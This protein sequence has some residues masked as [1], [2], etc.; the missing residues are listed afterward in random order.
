[1]A[2]TRLFNFSFF[3][4]EE[5]AEVSMAA[6][7]L[8]QGLWFLADR[9]GRLEDRPRRIKAD[10]FP[11][12][13]VDVESELHSLVQ[14]GF[15]QRY[16]VDGRRCIWVV[17]FVKHQHP[18]PHEAKSVLPPTPECN[19]MQL[20]VTE[21]NVIPG[22]VANTFTITSTV[23][24]AKTGSN[25]A[26]AHARES[27]QPQGTKPTTP[28]NPLDAILAKVP[29]STRQKFTNEEIQKQ[30]DRAMLWVSE[31]PTRFMS[32]KFFA[33]WL[34]REVTQGHIIPENLSEVE[35]LQRIMQK[36]PNEKGLIDGQTL[37]VWQGR[38]REAKQLA[39]AHAYQERC[40][41]RAALDALYAG[42]ETVLVSDQS[43]N[44]KTPT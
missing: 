39:E 24:A 4:N 6:R 36:K 44:H 1:M 2:N 18:H 13:D 21:S 11:Y 8:F 41:E 7:L 26:R 19:D 5:L 31:E 17:N 20:H 37:H 40:R 23:A 34:D 14:H 3:R 28:L 16:E 25:S 38:L 27:K 10:I 32:A 9:E 35:K 33:D 30:F 29:S 12:D 42:D 15:I 22:Y 43:S